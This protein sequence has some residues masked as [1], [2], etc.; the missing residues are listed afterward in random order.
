MNA[1]QACPHA[2]F[3]GLHTF[4]SCIPPPL[5]FLYFPFSATSF[6]SLLSCI[7]QAFIKQL[8]EGVSFPWS[9][10]QLFPISP[11]PWKGLQK[12]LSL[13][14]GLS[15]GLGLGYKPCVGGWGS[16]WRSSLALPS[17][18]GFRLCVDRL[19]EPPSSTQR[20]QSGL[21]YMLSLSHRLIL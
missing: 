16:L 12:P 15:L 14:Q 21:L 11:A 5:I 10:C 8:E 7:C 17:K 9:S 13:G 4:H 6:L 19:R 3:V 20:N 2:D 18:P 1:A